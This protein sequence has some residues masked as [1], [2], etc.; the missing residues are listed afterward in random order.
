MFQLPRHQRAR[1]HV[2]SARVLSSRCP[3]RVGHSRKQAQKSIVPRWWEGEQR[4][5]EEEAAAESTTN[6]C[7]PSGGCH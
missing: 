4:G 3:V 7:R 1:L 5:R 6:K 2:P